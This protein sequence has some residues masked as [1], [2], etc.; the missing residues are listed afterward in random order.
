[1]GA[2]TLVEYRMKWY[3]EEESVAKK[4]VAAEPDVME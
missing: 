1:M 3:G 4:K 2:M